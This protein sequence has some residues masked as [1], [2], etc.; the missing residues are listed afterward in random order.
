MCW[1]LVVEG[2]RKDEGERRSGFNAQK[3]E[4]TAISRKFHLR[5]LA[6]HVLV[7]YKH[8]GSQ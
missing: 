7:L 2:S 6:E 3:G 1:N 4:H 5:S 8:E